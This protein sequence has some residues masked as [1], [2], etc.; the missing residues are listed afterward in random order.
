MEAALSSRSPRTRIAAKIAARY[1]VLC[2]FFLFFFLRLCVAIFLSFLLRP[3]GTLATPWRGDPDIDEARPRLDCRSIV[4]GAGISVKWPACPPQKGETG[5]RAG[6]MGGLAK[7][8]RL[9]YNRMSIA[10]F[11]S[12]TGFP[13]REKEP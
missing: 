13:R 5:P 1:L 6:A 8:N 11:R 12:Q 7:Q 10:A 3:Q 9:D 2:L 4:H